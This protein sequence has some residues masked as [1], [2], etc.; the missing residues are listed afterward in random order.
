M[1]SRSGMAALAIVA[2][3]VVANGRAVADGNATVEKTVYVEIQIA[4]LGPDGCR[5]D[6]KPGHPACQF[7]AIQKSIAASD[8]QD[9]VR[10]EAIPVIARATGADHDCSFA[11]TV[12]EPNLPAKTIRRGILLTETPTGKTATAQVLKVYVNSPTL[13]AKDEKGKTKR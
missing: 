10:L 4:G 11:I 8:V 2:S 3:M 7:K 13:A 9:V 5:I 1:P 6:I 12:K